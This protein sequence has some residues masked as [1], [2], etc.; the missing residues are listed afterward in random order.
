M[1]YVTYNLL[2]SGNLGIR[3][4][5]FALTLNEE[6]KRFPPINHWHNFAIH[7]KHM[8]EAFA[9]LAF[10][11]IAC[12]VKNHFVKTHKDKWKISG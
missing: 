10:W 5:L 8:D 11:G 7:L 1:F 12:F 3:I 6:R 4:S 2:L 9:N